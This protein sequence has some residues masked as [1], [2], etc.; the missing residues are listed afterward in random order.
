MDKILPVYNIKQFRHVDDENNFYANELIPHLTEH[1]FT[2]KP[3]KHDF[4]LLLLFLLLLLMLMLT[5][6]FGHVI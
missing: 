6:H 4:Y 3:H 2:A 1:H 5:Y